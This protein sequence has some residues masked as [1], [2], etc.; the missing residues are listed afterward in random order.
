MIPQINRTN[1]TAIQSNKTHPGVWCPL[2]EPEQIIE[3]RPR[4]RPRKD[5]S[6]KE[7]PAPPTDSLTKYRAKNRKASARCREKERAQAVALEKVHQEQTERNVGLK[8]KETELREELFGLQMQALHHEYC[9]CKDVQSY[10]K[11]RAQEIADS[12]DLRV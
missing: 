3:S 6:K 11:R 8:Q 1:E 12:W 7:A 9:E 4:G 5:W 2:V 10:N